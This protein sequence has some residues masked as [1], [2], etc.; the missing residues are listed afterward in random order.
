MPLNQTRSIFEADPD[1][2]PREPVQYKE[3]DFRLS[4]YKTAGVDFPEALTE[5][6]VF[7]KTQETGDAIAQLMGGVR[8]DSENAKFPSE[9]YTN[10]G[11]IEVIIS[12]ISQDFKLWN[13]G[14]LTHHCD[15]YTF[16]STPPGPGEAGSPCGCP[17]DVKARKKA[18]TDKWGPRPSIEMSL[19]L[20][21]DP[22]LGAGELKTGSWDLVSDLHAWL[23]KRIDASM[24]QDPEGKVAATLYSKVVEYET[25]AGRHVRYVYPALRNIRPLSQAVTEE[26]GY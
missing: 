23:G 24:A 21:E 7:T 18:A 13:S 20:A 6:L 10:A 5:F 8:E 15:G 19:Q 4:V 25:K 14:T 17:T 2:A 1:A 3:A 9:V 12:D 26:P 22:D 11:E 16:L